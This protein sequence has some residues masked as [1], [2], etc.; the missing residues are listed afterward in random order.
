MLSLLIGELKQLSGFYRRKSLRS[1]K[2][3]R[4]KSALLIS[5]SE[6]GDGLQFCF[7]TLSKKFRSCSPSIEREG[8]EDFYFFTFFLSLTAHKVGKWQ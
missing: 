6:G 4:I 3:L 7:L 1:V 8:N 2:S 5:I